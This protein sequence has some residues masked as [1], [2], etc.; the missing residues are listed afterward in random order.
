MSSQAMFSKFFP[1]A[2]KPLIVIKHQK[3]FLYLVLAVNPALAIMFKI[4]KKLFKT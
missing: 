2:K 4:E 1:D 3:I